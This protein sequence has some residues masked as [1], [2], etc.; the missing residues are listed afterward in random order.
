MPRHSQS[1]CN[2][3]CAA[4]TGFSD[5]HLIRGAQ[6]LFVKRHP[7]VDDILLFIRIFLDL[8]IMRCNEKICTRFFQLF[9]NRNRNSHAFR[10]ICPRPQL[11]HNDKAVSVYFVQHLQHIFNM[12][13]KCRQILCQILPVPDIAQI[14]AVH[15]YIRFFACDMQPALR[16]HAV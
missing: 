12:S 2:I 13:R 10:R 15:A 16:H 1:V 9:Q 4:L 14:R 8:W 6:R 5:Y 11:I 3:K 7:G